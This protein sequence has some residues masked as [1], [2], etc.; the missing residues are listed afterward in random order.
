MK[1]NVPGP[2][3]K[4]R[5]KKSA[6]LELAG[7]VKRLRERLTM[8]RLTQ[9]GFARLIGVKQSAVSAWEQGA[10][11]PSDQNYIRLGNAALSQEDVLWFWGRAGL[12][13]KVFER[14][15]DEILESRSE[16]GESLPIN[17]LVYIK[18]LLGTEGDD[19][20]FPLSLV[21]N[22]LS[23]RYARIPEPFVSNEFP[24]NFERGDVL[25]ID[26]SE[27]DLRKIDEGSLVAMDFQGGKRPLNADEARFAFTFGWLE[28]QDATIGDVSTLH[29][30]LRR[31]FGDSF[32]GSSVG[33]LAV[34]PIR[35]HLVLGRVIAW[36]AFPRSDFGLRKEIGNG[37]RSK[38]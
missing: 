1:K 3:R 11:P 26:T 16:T 2:R 17:S 25:L 14:V 23:T 34:E 37:Q 30:M 8:Q 18:P 32:I 15:A 27:T 5:G 21:P 31:P 10:P 9:E 33:S 12:D 29:F 24:P 38:D 7:R 28:K 35:Q 36:V 19:L 6:D 13:V 4:T 20:L 22:P